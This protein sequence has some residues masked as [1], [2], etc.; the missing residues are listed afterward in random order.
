MIPAVLRRWRHRPRVT[1]VVVAFNMERE[2]PRTL[3]S[4]RPP[5][6]RGLQEC[7]VEVIVVDNGSRT[8]P[9]PHDL[10]PGTVLLQVDAPTH[11]PVRAIN[12]GLERARGDLVSVMID[13]ARMAS[14]GLL[15]HALLA[16]QLHDRPIITSLGFHLGPEVQMISVEQGYG[17][18]E[19]D[20][21]LAS[22][23]WQQDGY[24]LFDISVFA[25][26]SRE[27]WFLP[28]AESN[29][30]FLSRALWQELGGYDERFA[31]PGGGLANLDTY[32]RA[33]DL[34]ETQLITLLGEGTFHQVHGGVATNQK[35]PDADWATFHREYVEIRRKTFAKPTKTPIYLGTIAPQVR[36]TVLQSARFLE[37][38]GSTHA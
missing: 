17:Q 15:F 18:E 34:P 35:R 16:S 27:G 36:K 23:D 3:Y 14:P 29:A 9:R 5:Y 8:P 30:L 21:L 1:V 32:V 11:S 4:L 20:R 6:Q 28:V 7:D 22:I 2:L 10:P 19:E 31:T 12:L 37:D 25:G 24:R 38:H 33:C 26:S 13:G